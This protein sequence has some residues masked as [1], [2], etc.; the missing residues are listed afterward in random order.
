MSW[1][2]EPYDQS[3][4]PWL[5]VVGEPAERVL[6]VSEL[7]GWARARQRGCGHSEPT[8]SCRMCRGTLAVTDMFGLSDR[9]RMYPAV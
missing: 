3:T 4:L 8:P 7:D 1:Q 2:D 6:H 5:G 9:V